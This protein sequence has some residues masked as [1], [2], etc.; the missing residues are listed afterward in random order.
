MCVCV[1]QAVDVGKVKVY[2]PAVEA[3]VTLHHVSYLIVDCKEAGPGSSVRQ[4]FCIRHY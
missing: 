3:P 2:G 1:S 4:Y